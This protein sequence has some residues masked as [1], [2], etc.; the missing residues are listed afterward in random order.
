MK[1]K[2]WRILSNNLITFLKNVNKKHQISTG[3]M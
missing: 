2:N 3:V 1:T